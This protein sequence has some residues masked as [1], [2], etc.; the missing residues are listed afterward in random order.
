MSDFLPMATH[1]SK[2][3]S[4]AVKCDF[5]NSCEGAPALRGSIV[6]RYGKA[7]TPSGATDPLKIL[8]IGDELL[9]GSVTARRYLVVAR[10]VAECQV[11]TCVPALDRAARARVQV[12]AQ[13]ITGSR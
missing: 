1:T 13:E 9:V 12:S 3:H 5:L 11:C 10:A 4:S 8:R 2:P 7:V 6:P